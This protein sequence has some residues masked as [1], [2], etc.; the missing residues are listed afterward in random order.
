M[1][2]RSSRSI[3]PDP[4]DS[5]T[6]VTKD[7][8]ISLKNDIQLL[9]TKDDL[10]HLL[11]R[12][13]VIEQALKAKDDKIVELEAKVDAQQAKI[14]DLEAKFRNLE[15][16][17]DNHTIHSEKQYDELEQYGRRTS[18]RIDGINIA[19]HETTDSLEQSVI[20]KIRSDC[21]IDIQPHDI[22]RL[23]RIGPKYTDRTSNQ[24]GQQVIVKFRSFKVR[25]RVYQARPRRRPREQASRKIRIA[26]DLTSRRYALLKKARAEL[27][28]RDSYVYA[29]MNCRMMLNRGDD[30]RAIPFYSEAEFHDLIWLT[31][32]VNIKNLN[33]V[34]WQK[35]PN[36]LF[37]GRPSPWGNPYKVHIYGRATCIAMYEDY[38]RG[39]PE[40][41]AMLQQLVNMELGC[42]CKPLPC[43]GDILLKIMKEQGLIWV[44]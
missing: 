3:M 39:S 26:L 5:E 11:A 36:S 2:T 19:A 33:F 15:T 27:E 37:I 10:K 22:N 40:L 21:S 4:I 38:I 16:K 25:Q 14:C 31:T 23:H 20:N 17:I 24:Q 41:M 13:D 34:E 29:D 28:G 8:I 35:Q 1:Q 43:H 12:F 30:S 9:A 6:G 7:D 42:G 44:F 18:L 32:V